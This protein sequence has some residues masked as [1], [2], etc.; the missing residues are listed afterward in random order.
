[1]DCPTPFGSSCACACK[2]NTSREDRIASY[3]EHMRR[4]LTDDPTQSLPFTLPEA[5]GRKWRNITLEDLRYACA[6]VSALMAE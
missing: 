3:A 2:N 5:V 1:M 4:L 6:L